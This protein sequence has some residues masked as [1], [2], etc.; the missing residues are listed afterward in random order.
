MYLIKF[1]TIRYYAEC[2]HTCHLCNYCTV[3]NTDNIAC[4]AKSNNTS[5]NKRVHA[6]YRL[7]AYLLL[8]DSRNDTVYTSPPLPVIGLFLNSCTVDEIGGFMDS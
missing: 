7:S 3:Q 4:D 8:I 5:D 2:H 6:E 1:S